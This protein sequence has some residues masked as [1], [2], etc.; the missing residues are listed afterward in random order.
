MKTKEKLPQEIKVIDLAR[1]GMLL[2][3]REGL[4]QQCAVQ[5]E[6]EL[7]HNQQSLY[8]QYRFYKDTGRWP[9]WHDAM[10]H[11]TEPMKKFWVNGLRQQGVKIGRAPRRPKNGGK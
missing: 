9:T 1:E 3:P 7:P 6:P 5:H 2:P 10:A 11:C 8:W 4:C